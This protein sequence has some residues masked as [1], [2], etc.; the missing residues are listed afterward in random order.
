WADCDG[1]AGP[2]TLRALQPARKCDLIKGTVRVKSVRPKRRKVRATRAPYAYDVPLDPQSPWPKFRRTSRQDGRS[3]ITPSLTGG[4]LWTFQTGKGI[5]STPVIGGD[6][7]VYVGSADRTFYA[8]D[9]DG[10]L[11]WSRLTGEIIDSSALLDD[12]GRIYFGSG[13][14]HL[15]ALDRTTGEPVWTFT[16]DDPA[17]NSAF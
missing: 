11:K 14:G 12:R 4:H 13:D 8:I 17:V 7:T 9:R 15:Y 16:A 6:G 3:P 1:I 2:V 10:R 5:F